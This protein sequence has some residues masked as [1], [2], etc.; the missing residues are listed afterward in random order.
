MPSDDGR[1]LGGAALEKLA[2]RGLRPARVETRDRG[3][4]FGL[5]RKRRPEKPALRRQRQQAQRRLGDDAERA[6]AADE[7]REQ[8]VAGDV[9][10][11]LA[12]EREDR[13]AR[14]HDAQSRDVP[15]GRAVAG[16]ARAA[17]VLR[18]VAADRAGTARGRVRRIEEACRLG[19]I[20]QRLRHDAR[21]DD[22]EE[23]V[24][25]ELEDPVH[26][27]EVE[28]DAAL[29]R[30]RSARKAG[31]GAL[32][33]HREPQL[34][35]G[36]EQRRPPRT[37]TGAAPRS[38]A[39][40]AGP[41]SRRGNARPATPRRNAGFPRGGGGRALRPAGGSPRRKRSM[42]PGAPFRPRPPAALE[43]PGT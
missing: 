43:S 3:E 7:E 32:G 2:G 34:A 11:I 26:G 10:P 21:L 40:R 14:N 9:L 8:V 17:G 42:T 4:G 29:G 22:R 12:A 24:P 16:G 35:R 19:R 36:R 1:D 13:P 20:L 38:R 33:R 18:D 27:A 41:R 37:P 23:I 28:R 15:A 6:L 30:Q 31:P 5:P 25:V 39:G